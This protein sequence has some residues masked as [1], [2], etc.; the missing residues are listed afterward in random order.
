MTM[1]ST[2]RAHPTLAADLSIFFRPRGVAVIGASADPQKLGHGIVH[3]LIA[4]R[5]PGCIYPI[6]PREDAI[7]DLK[8]Y[9]HIADVPDPVDLAVIIVP[10]ERVPAQIEAC[11]QRGLKAANPGGAREVLIP[12]EGRIAHNSVVLSRRL[13]LKKIA[14]RDFGIE[15]FSIKQRSSLG[16]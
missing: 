11:G 8:T 5:Y 1:Y 10:A 2:L 13:V 16:C 12:N 6:N 7:L 4:N 9:P 14:D 15:A 3:N